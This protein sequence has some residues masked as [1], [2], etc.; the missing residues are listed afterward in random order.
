MTTNNDSPEQNAPGHG[1]PTGDGERDLRRELDE[2]DDRKADA[3]RFI[4]D[5]DAERERMLADRPKH[6]WAGKCTCLPMVDGNLR[7]DPQCPVHG[8]FAD[9][10]GVL[11][12]KAAGGDDPPGW[13]KLY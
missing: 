9:E 13:V 4:A 3:L 12:R 7:R 1:G 5:V 2:L 6:P 11:D 8:H 10:G